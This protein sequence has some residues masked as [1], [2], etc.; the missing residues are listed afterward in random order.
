MENHNNNINRE[1]AFLNIIQKK[2]VGKNKRKR[3]SM[4]SAIVVMK[5]VLLY[6]EIDFKSSP[7]SLFKSKCFGGYMEKRNR[8]WFLLYFIHYLIFLSIWNKW[9]DN[10]KSKTFFF[11]A[12]HKISFQMLVARFWDFDLIFSVWVDVP[13]SILKE[14]KIV[15]THFRRF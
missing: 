7:C 2:I 6:L 11:E 3:I 4:H 9:T 15:D 5:L 8:E 10:D 14:I 13:W 1:K 12:L